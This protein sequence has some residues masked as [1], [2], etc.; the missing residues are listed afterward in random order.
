MKSRIMNAQKRTALVVNHE[1]GHALAPE[2]VPYADPVVRARIL[3]RGRG[4][5]G[6]TMQM[7]TED[8]HLK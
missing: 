2:L 6:H 7:P 3:P 4:I 5:L 8:L 1:S